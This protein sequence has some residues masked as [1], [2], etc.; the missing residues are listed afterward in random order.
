MLIS[1]KELRPRVSNGSGRIGQKMDI[2]GQ[3]WTDRKTFCL[4]E[5]PQIS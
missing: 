4:H 1:H 3:K 2:D 5:I